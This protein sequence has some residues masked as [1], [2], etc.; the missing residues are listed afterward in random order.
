MQTQQFA[1]GMFVDIFLSQEGLCFVV[2]PTVLYKIK[3]NCFIMKN[4]EQIKNILPNLK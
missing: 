4:T 3:N 2:H 1:T